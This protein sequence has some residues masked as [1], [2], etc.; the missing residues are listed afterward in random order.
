M[1]QTQVRPLAS[2]QAVSIAAVVL[3]ALAACSSGGSG[4]TQPIPP[5]NPVAV[6][7]TPTTVTLVGGTGTQQFAA[8]VTNTTN[9]DVNW[10]VNSVA[11][12]NSTVGTISATG[13][14]TATAG[15]V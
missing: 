11:G 8:D 7:V 2:V 10:S 13:L 15:A 3:V 1:I 14:Y 12:G 4:G 9:T 5:S 6:T